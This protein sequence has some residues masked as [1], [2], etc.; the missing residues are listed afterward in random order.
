MI[1]PECVE[2]RVEDLEIVAPVDE[3]RPACV[4]NLVTRS[5][6]Y[7]LQRL[8]DIEEPPN[9]HVKAEAPERAPEDDQVLDKAGHWDAARLAARGGSLA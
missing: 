6:V 7:V 2:R 9:M 1:A 5:D 3:Q 4:V 8:S